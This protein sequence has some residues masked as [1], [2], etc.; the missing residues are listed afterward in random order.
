M[1]PAPPSLELTSGIMIEWERNSY[2][3]CWC[4]GIKGN[5]LK[6]V[7]GFLFFGSVGADY[8]RNSLELR[9]STSFASV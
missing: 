4:H 1:G 8:F 6:D 5:I 7:G 2:L 3:F 9:N